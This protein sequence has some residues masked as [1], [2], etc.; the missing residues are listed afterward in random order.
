MSISL[1]PNDDLNPGD[2]TPP[3]M[4][5]EVR[6]L[7]KLFNE[8]IDTLPSVIAEEVASSIVGQSYYN[9]DRSFTYFPTIVLIFREKGAL[10]YPR[11]S[12]V[13][14]RLKADNKSVTDDFIRR[15]RDACAEKRGFEY[16]YGRVRGNFVS[17]DKRW[18]TTVFTSSKDEGTKLLSTICDLVGEPFLMRNVSWTEGR[19]RE[20]PF[21][22]EETLDS[23]DPSPPFENQEPQM[24][25][26]RVVMLVNGL[27]RPIILLRC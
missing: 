17:S 18:K 11:R 8:K 19:E 6:A 14:A 15:L 27:P 23:I 9:Y 26:H 20:N 21:R 7:I 16:T 12:Q 22:R 25:L 5:L 10:Q 13:K 3:D 2:A 24:C 4:A 1:P